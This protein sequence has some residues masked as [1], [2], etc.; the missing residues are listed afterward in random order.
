MD[1]QDILRRPHA[2]TPPS[3]HDVAHLGRVRKVVDWRGRDAVSFRYDRATGKPVRVADRLGNHRILEYDGAGNCVKLSRRAGWTVSTEP[4]RSFSYDRAGRLASVS[5]LDADGAAVRTVS[6]SRYALGRVVGEE[7]ADG[8]AVSYAYDA[9]GRL[10]REGGRAYRYGYL[11]KVL[12][13]TE[14]KRK[15]TYTYHAD[16]QLAT[17]DF[18]DGRAERFAWDS[19]ALVRRGDEWFVNEPHVGG[20]APV[21]SSKGA[22][23]FNDILGTTVCVREGRASSRPKPRGKC[24]AAALTA[25]GEPLPGAGGDAFF[26]GKPQVEGLGRVFLYRNYRASLAKWQ[27]ADP[28]GYPDGWNQLAYCE[29]GVT[30]ALDLFGAHT[31]AN[32]EFG[33]TSSLGL[34]CWYILVAECTGNYENLD[35]TYS[36]TMRNGSL[37]SFNAPYSH[38]DER[39]GMIYDPTATISG[40]SSATKNL[41]RRSSK[42]SEINELTI[43]FDWII[44]YTVNMSYQYEA[45]DPDTG[46]NKVYTG[47]LSLPVQKSKHVVLH[48]YHRKME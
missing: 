37:T 20:G 44:S 19:L 8:S 18:G 1:S 5:E 36:I 6:V 38:Y 33:Y 26:T 25:F 7:H 21:V 41:Q 31:I 11:D 27:T 9:A 29:N 39:Y 17:A 3:R 10:V 35:I 45:K 2:A 32:D 15:L 4:V 30:G 46:E 28:F 40:F 13:V 47:H 16:G 24:T 12:S 23:Y 43:E 42:R 34:G 48:C 14:G 22:S